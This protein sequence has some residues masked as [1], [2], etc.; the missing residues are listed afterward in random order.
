MCLRVRGTGHTRENDGFRFV[1]IGLP[2]SLS[3]RVFDSWRG[4]GYWESPSPWYVPQWFHRTWGFWFQADVVYELVPVSIQPPTYPVAPTPVCAVVILP[5]IE[6][7]RVVRL[8]GG[9]ALSYDTSNII[10]WFDE[11]GV[12]T[13]FSPPPDNLSN[14]RVSRRGLRIWTQVHQRCRAL[15]GP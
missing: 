9:G 8:Y 5:T 1:G 11:L 12:L 13:N 6:L 10:R 2:P 7:P 4:G 14:P 3:I 15:H